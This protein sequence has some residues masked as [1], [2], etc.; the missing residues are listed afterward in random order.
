MNKLIMSLICSG[1]FSSPRSY[2]KDFE[3]AIKSSTKWNLQRHYEGLG[4]SKAY[5]LIRV[6]DSCEFDNTTLI[7]F[8]NQLINLRY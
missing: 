1:I 3:E 6:M 4:V 7:R 5:L 2:E 8:K